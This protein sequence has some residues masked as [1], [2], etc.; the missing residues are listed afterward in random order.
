MPGVESFL[1]W[2]K[3][4]LAGKPIVGITEVNIWRSN[5][6]GFPEVLIA[7]KEF[8]A[9]HYIRAS[10]GVTMLVRGESERSNYLVHVNGSQVDAL[11]G[12]FGGMVRWFAERRLTAEAADVMQGLRRRLESGEPPA[13]LVRESP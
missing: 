4:R 9:T 6:V 5:E 10:P 2:S 1:Y 13:A 8:F 11:G 7:G 3:E 12:V